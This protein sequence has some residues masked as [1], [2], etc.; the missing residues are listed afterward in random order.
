METTAN[1]DVCLALV[2]PT[3]TCYCNAQPTARHALIMASAV[4][5]RT[6]STESSAC[7][8]LREPMEP[9]AL[10][11]N[12]VPTVLHAHVPLL[13]HARSASL[14]TRGPIVRPN[15]PLAMV[16]QTA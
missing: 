1:R 10:K 3:A 6:T 7:H 8:A 14:D 4:N 16:V 11:T 9:T 2:E 5:V 13:R 12:V 15:A